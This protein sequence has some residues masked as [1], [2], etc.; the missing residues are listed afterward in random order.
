ME[1]EKLIMIS[2]FTIICVFT[3]RSAYNQL[4]YNFI[5]TH[6]TFQTNNNSIDKLIAATSNKPSDEDVKLA[7]QTILRFIK[8]DFNKG[9]KI[10]DDMRNRF[11]SP[12]TQLKS[13]FD[14]EKILQNPLVL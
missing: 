14:I 12:T 3:L 7:Y 1:I 6:E 5:K 10:I 4:R 9:A 8:S 13:D 2:L 11:F